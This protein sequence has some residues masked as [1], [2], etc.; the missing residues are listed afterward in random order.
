MIPTL[1][2]PYCTM[3]AL[4]ATGGA[5]AK[6]VTEAEVIAA[7]INTVE[8]SRVKMIQVAEGANCGESFNACQALRPHHPPPHPSKHSSM[9]DSPT[10][11]LSIPHALRPFNDPPHTLAD[12]HGFLT[13]GCI[14][15]WM[16]SMEATR[17]M[18]HHATPCNPT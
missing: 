6:V 14:L 17:T 7:P 11:S 9:G 10:H 5:E 1:G 15:K 4:A 8:G 18:W 2:P 13:T 12:M 3:A 16:V